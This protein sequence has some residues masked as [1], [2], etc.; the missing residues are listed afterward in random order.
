M[1]EQRADKNG[2]IVTRHVR[3]GDY[4]EAKKSFPPPVPTRAKSAVQEDAEVVAEVIYSHSLMKPEERMPLD[5]VTP[6]M[7]ELFPEETIATA[8]GIL[9]ADPKNRTHEWLMRGVLELAEDASIDPD[10]VNGKPQLTLHNVITKV[11]QARVIAAAEGFGIPDREIRT[12]VR[13]Q[14]HKALVIT[15]NA[16][17]AGVASKGSDAHDDIHRIKVAL[18]LREVISPLQIAEISSDADTYDEMHRLYEEI[19]RI[20]P[21]LPE[22]QKRGSFSFEL[23][24]EMESS[25]SP[26]MN[27]GLL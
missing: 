17:R 18:L 2:K 27:S 26:V 9:R 13:S 14:D 15:Q 3:Q 19:D 21:Y 25:S 22:L 10:G 20:L 6:F 1:P 11:D 8:A 7:I 4:S 5:E 23:L 16:I 24:E 12:M